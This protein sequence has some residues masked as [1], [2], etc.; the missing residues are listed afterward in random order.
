MTTVLTFL[1]VNAVLG[2]WDTL[3]YH[4][5]RARLVARVDS[6]RTELRLHAARD[7]IYV[8]LY[9]V[10]AW[11]RPAGVVVAVVALLLVAE[12]VITLA[13]FVVEDRDRPAIGGIAP[14]ERILHSMM[15]IVYGMMLVQLLPVLAA[16]LADPSGL[17]RHDAPLALSLAGAAAAAGIAVS[18]LRDVLAL[19]GFDPVWSS[20]RSESDLAR[21][22]ARASDPR[23]QARGIARYAWAATVAASVVSVVVI[24]LRSDR[25][26]PR[27]SRGS[28]RGSLR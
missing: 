3:W 17:V 7:G 23:P 15:A 9:G 4:E 20:P 10:L 19:R 12:I 21:S 24:S 28:R 6:T 5:Y 27:P 1:L 18:G 2:A 16:S 14:G 25:P 13:D 22:P 26:S 8:V 11:W